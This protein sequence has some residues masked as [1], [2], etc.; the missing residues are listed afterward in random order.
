MQTLYNDIS[1]Q[2]S[3]FTF[4]KTYSEECGSRDPLYEPVFSYHFILLVSR[5]GYSFITD[6]GKDQCFFILNERRGFFTP[7]LIKEEERDLYI[8]GHPEKRN[9]GNVMLGSFE[10]YTKHWG[11]QSIPSNYIIPNDI[12]K[13]LQGDIND[14]VFQ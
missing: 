4:L 1:H 2:S 11:M 8:G 6:I 10:L 13:V 3:S 14:R 9:F 5:Y 7:R 12:I